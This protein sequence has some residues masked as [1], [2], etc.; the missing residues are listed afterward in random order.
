MFWP[1]LVCFFQTPL[2]EYVISELYT[3]ILGSSTLWI[4][5]F[6][7]LLWINYSSYLLEDCHTVSFSDL[8]FLI[9]LEIS[10]YLA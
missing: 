4:T 7:P 9:H 8:M 2:T 1:G 5:A 6:L 10:C 3:W